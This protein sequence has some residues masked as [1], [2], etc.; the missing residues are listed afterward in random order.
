MIKDGQVAQDQT[1]DV[2]VIEVTVLLLLI[3]AVTATWRWT[4]RRRTR[5]DSAARR[6]ANRKDLALLKEL[7]EAG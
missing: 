2:A 1:V 7:L 6:M 3:T 4:R 5:V